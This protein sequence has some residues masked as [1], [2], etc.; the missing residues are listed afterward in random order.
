MAEMG[1]SRIGYKLQDI[2]TQKITPSE[3]QEMKELSGSYEALFSRR[4][5]KYKQV[6]KEI[7]Q[8]TEDIYRDL[9]LQEYTF[10]KRPVI[11]AGKKILIGSE[12]K[13]VEQMLEFV[14]KHK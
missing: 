14:R 9:I 4:A 7:T 10:L 11:I 8:W 1:E 3:L 2:K 12:K 5:L 13:V 6:Q